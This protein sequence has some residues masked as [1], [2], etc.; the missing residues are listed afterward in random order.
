MGSA[1]DGHCSYNANGRLHQDLQCPHTQ[2]QPKT[3]PTKTA[4]GYSAQYIY[5]YNCIDLHVVLKWVKMSISFLLKRECPIGT[6]RRRQQR[7]AN[8]QP[9]GNNP[10]NRENYQMGQMRRWDMVLLFALVLP[11]AYSG[12]T[13][14][15]RVT[16]T[17]SCKIQ[18]TCN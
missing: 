12:S 7:Q 5:T 14:L 10:R 1:V 2:Q 4:S 17:T 13:S 11:S 8:A 9:Q 6:L 16:F 18:W 3:S 15:Q